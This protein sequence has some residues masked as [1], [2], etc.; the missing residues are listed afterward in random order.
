MVFLLPVGGDNDIVK[1]DNDP[2][3]LAKSWDFW[4]V[5]TLLV[6]EPLLAHN[7]LDR[8]T[9]P[10]GVSMMLL[11]GAAAVPFGP[12]P[13]FEP[14]EVILRRLRDRTRSGAAGSVVAELIAERRQDAA[15]E[16]G[17]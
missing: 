11:S 17:S 10:L 13:G 5:G 9:I 12:R 1:I 2:A 14:P 6:W 4:S 16:A 3:Q 7:H 15:D 8:V